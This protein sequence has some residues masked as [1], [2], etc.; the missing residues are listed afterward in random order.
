M[1]KCCLSY[2]LKGEARPFSEC[3]LVKIADF[4]SMWLLDN[5]RNVYWLKGVIAPFFIIGSLSWSKWPQRVF[6][7]RLQLMKWKTQFIRIKDNS[8][9]QSL[10]KYLNRLAFLTF[11]S[12]VLS[13]CVT[14]CVGLKAPNSVCLMSLASLIISEVISPVMEHELW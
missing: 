14:F 5:V 7:W 9:F 8:T 10:S 3:S 2:S 4:R 1:I 12:W 11:S 13:L 6:F